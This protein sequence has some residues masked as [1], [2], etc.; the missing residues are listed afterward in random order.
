MGKLEESQGGSYSREIGDKARAGM[1]YK[2]YYKTL[3]VSKTASEKE[4]KA[5]YRKLA[6]KHHPDMNQGNAKAE[7]RFKEINEAYE[8]LSDPEK[9]RKYDQLGADWKTY[10]RQPGAGAGALARRGRR[11][12]G[13]RLRRGGAGRLLGLLQDVLRGRRLRRLRGC[14]GR[15]RAVRL[16]PRRRH[17][18]RGR[19]DARGG[20]EGRHEDA[21][22]RR[23]GKGPPRGGEDPARASARAS[24]CAWPAKGPR[25][26]GG[27]R[28][29]LYLRVQIK[30]D[31]GFERKGD[32]LQT[33]VRV[34]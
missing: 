23:R 30:P 3:G 25:A 8:V 9:R 31:P 28:G 13:I 14:R 2:D 22:A 20:A 34:P 29:D 4:I 1:D 32:D 21:R 26:R 18:A 16:D 27:K 19:A 10:A 7:A 5:A 6:R 12:R 33:T 24:A 11:S 15:R 17:R